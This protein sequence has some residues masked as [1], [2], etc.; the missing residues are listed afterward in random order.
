MIERGEGGAEGFIKGIQKE[1]HEK[2][3][4]A[5]P[6]R[7]KYIEKANG[8]FGAIMDDLWSGCVSPSACCASR[9]ST[10]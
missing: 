10:F 8:K 9:S 5:S 4:R 2:T 3:Y 1:L 6:L 7:R